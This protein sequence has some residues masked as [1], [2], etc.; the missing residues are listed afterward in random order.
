MPDVRLH[1]PSRAENVALA[2]EVVTGLAEAIGLSR[3]QYDDIRTAVTEACDN[4][5]QHAYLDEPGPLEVDIH[6]LTNA[7]EVIVRDR[8]IGVASTIGGDDQTMSVG[9]PVMLALAERVELR[10]VP[11]GGTSVRMRFP[12]PGLDPLPARRSGG[13]GDFGLDAMPLEG[14]PVVARLS[15]ARIGLARTIL[16]RVA[17]A[18]AARAHFSLDRV[19]DVQ[20]LAD[21]VCAHVDPHSRGARLEIAM[22]VSARCIE[23]Q[24]GPLTGGGSEALLRASSDG[25]PVIGL[26]VDHSASTRL[27]APDGWERLGLRL[28]DG[29]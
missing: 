15:F 5:V 11:G 17:C 27:P 24:L 10:R 29:S 19:S 13:S 21:A 4:V 8:G 6:V 25:L 1:V 12:T 2:R 22:A 16:P 3:E 7:V 14:L 23:L 9:L 26:L 18:L 20:L 28:L